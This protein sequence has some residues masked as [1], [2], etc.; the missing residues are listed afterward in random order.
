MLL[1]LSH[2]S[3]LFGP[4]LPQCVSRDFEESYRF[5]KG[6][7]IGSNQQ[8]QINYINITANMVLFSMFTHTVSTLLFKKNLKRQ[9]LFHVNVIADLAALLKLLSSAKTEAGYDATLPAFLLP[10]QC[11][12]PMTFWC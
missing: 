6:F 8:R 11:C 12:G 3:I 9:H 4:I 10:Q 1:F 5:R 7:T 2:R